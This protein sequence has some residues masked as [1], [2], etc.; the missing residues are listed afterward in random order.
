MQSYSLLVGIFCAAISGVIAAVAGLMAAFDGNFL[1]GL[2]AIFLVAPVCFA[3]MFTFSY[4]L[5]R[6]ESEKK[7][8]ELDPDPDEPGAWKPSQAAPT[9]DTAGTPWAN[10]PGA[11]EDR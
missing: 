3:Q 9:S 5:E 1:G 8:F 7:K 10:N 4:V 2:A 6:V 11:T